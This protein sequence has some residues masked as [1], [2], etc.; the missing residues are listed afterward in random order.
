MFCK[1]CGEEIKNNAN[2][3]G[4][5]GTAVTEN[6]KSMIATTQ[7]VTQSSIVR[8][9]PVTDSM[10]QGIYRLLEPLKMIDKYS[11]RISQL[12][13]EKKNVQN[14][15]NFTS[16]WFVIFCT[17]S[18]IIGGYLY[19][20]KPP[21]GIVAFMIVN[22][23]FLAVGLPII[24]WRTNVS[25]KERCEKSIAEEVNRVDE[26]CNK[27]NLNDLTLLPPSYRFC[28]AAT[29]IYNAFI[30]QRAFT[31]Q[32]A[33]NLYEDTV[34]KSQIEAM[35]QQQLQRLQSIQRTSTV[36]ATM[37]TLNFLHKVL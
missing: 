34:H 22:M 11:N 13:K 28:H 30:N 3:C 4:S 29:F 35:Q 23:V 33:V 1:E 15:I 27:I 36:T 21:A 14:A 12:E 17:V 26:V 25:R 10:I 31:M 24:L 32:Q 37:S 8:P 18:V 16:S 2:F 6:V 5:C 9:T 20:L 19:R 7:T